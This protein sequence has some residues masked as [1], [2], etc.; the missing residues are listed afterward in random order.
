MVR[1]KFILPFLLLGA[2][3]SC[4]REPCCCCESGCTQSNGM[5]WENK[6]STD[7]LQ[8]HNVSQKGETLTFRCKSHK[9]VG[10]RYL[11][12]SGELH[13]ADDPKALPSKIYGRQASAYVEGDK[14]IIYFSPY[15]SANSPRDF[16]VSV[17]AGNAVET[18]YF[19]Q[20]GKGVPPQPFY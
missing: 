4:D 10:I 20:Y 18:F 14:L 13:M 19:R 1:F 2:A 7:P 8:P 11:Q 12:E 17:G 5:K 16:I 9:N 3:V 6:P 15:E